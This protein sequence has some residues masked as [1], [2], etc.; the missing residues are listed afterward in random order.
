MRYNEWAQPLSQAARA[1]ANPE[2]PAD[3]TRYRY[4]WENRWRYGST[5]LCQLGVY[6]ERSIKGE[7]IEDCRA[8]G[9]P[10]RDGPRAKPGTCGARGP[11]G[12]GVG[13]PLDR[14]RVVRLA[15]R[16]GCFE[17]LGRNAPP[18][19]GG[20]VVMLFLFPECAGTQGI[21]QQA[22][23]C[24]QQAQ[25]NAAKIASRGSV[26]MLI[27]GGRCQDG[28]DG[29]DAWRAALQGF[30]F[31]FPAAVDR[32]GGA[33]DAL[34]KLGGRAISPGMGYIGLVLSPDGQIVRTGTCNDL[35][36]HIIDNKKG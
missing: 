5:N 18:D 33:I 2:H 31:D 3:W 10:K 32:N 13:I 24:L 11:T 9:P 26:F 36:L 28:R 15:R 16:V 20:K 4:L 22:Y 23:V 21:P 6:I 34:L 35:F 7:S 29:V 14:Q 19:L 25:N 27:A 1:T 17:D 12:H 30:G 8:A